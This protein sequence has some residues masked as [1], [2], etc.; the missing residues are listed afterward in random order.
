MTKHPDSWSF[1]NALCLS[2]MLG[3][4]CFLMAVAWLA[5]LRHPLV[6]PCRLEHHAF[7]QLVH[8]AALDFLPRRLAC[9]IIGVAAVL[10]Q[11]CAPLR[12]LGLGNEDV[13]RALAQVDADAIAGLE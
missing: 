9:G 11:R 13:G 1:Q 6:L 8:H 2:A 3:M 4:A 5:C 10:R 12:K 7:G